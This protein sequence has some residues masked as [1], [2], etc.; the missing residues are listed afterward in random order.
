MAEYLPYLELHVLII[1]PMD[2][3][4]TSVKFPKSPC[5]IYSLPESEDLKRPHQMG[6]SLKKWFV[7]LHL[8]DSRWIHDIKALNPLFLWRILLFQLPLL[9][10]SGIP[11]KTKIETGGKSF[12]CM[13][14]LTVVG[15]LQ[16]CV[17]VYLYPLSPLDNTKWVSVCIQG[18][19]V[20]F[21][22]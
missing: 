3:C 5:P 16:F 17:Y 15:I 18:Q 1:C 13:C 4:S 9:G 11:S 14:L 10:S 19:N 7:G 22:H 6:I 20:H 12:I 8:I 21:P 2:L